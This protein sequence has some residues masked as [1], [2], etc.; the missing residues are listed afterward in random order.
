MRLYQD[1][2]R[3]DEILVTSEVEVCLIGG[4]KAQRIPADVRRKLEN[5]N[6]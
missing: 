3:G 5:P 6:L 2:R 4:G 1:V